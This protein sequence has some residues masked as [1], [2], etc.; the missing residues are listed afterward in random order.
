MFK[1]IILLVVLA[2]CHQA[3]SMN[4]GKASGSR[5]MM[6]IVSRREIDAINPY[7]DEV[8]EAAASAKEVWPTFSKD[9]GGDYLLKSFTISFDDDGYG[10]KSSETSSDEWTPKI[11]EIQMLLLDE[12]E[13]VD[14][15]GSDTDSMYRAIL[16]TNKEIQRL[17]SGL[18]FKRY[19]EPSVPPYVLLAAAMF[20]KLWDDEYY[21]QRLQSMPNC[22]KFRSVISHIKALLLEDS[23]TYFEIPD[24]QL[25]APN[26]E[27]M[28]KLAPFIHKDISGI[29]ASSSNRNDIGA[30][31]GRGP[32]S[33][34]GA[35]G[36]HIDSVGY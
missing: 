28:P 19:R 17:L 12:K 27:Y 32:G 29:G 9:M 15:L 1:P 30:S 10:Y 22:R 13:T 3:I 7:R 23:T 33:S 25:R 11:E 8:T 21:G 36:R 31:S 6:K 18:P 5:N 24:N 20:Q 16:K 26:L 35:G 4:P 2:L 34:S 14:R